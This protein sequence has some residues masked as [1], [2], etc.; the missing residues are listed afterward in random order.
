MTEYTAPLRDMRFV[1]NDLV[2]M[3]RITALPGYEHA[4]PD[5]TD[6]ILEEA[7]KFAGNVLSPLNHSGDKEGARLDADGAHTAAGFA[8]AYRQFVDGG[9]SALGC[10]PAYGGQGLPAVLGTAVKEM[11]NAANMAFS[12]CPLLTT[13]AIEALHLVG[14][15]AQ[16][17]MY[18]PKM[19]EGTWTG[20][21]NLTEPQAGSDL[22]AIR[23]RAVPEGDHYRIYG[24][25]IFITYGDHDMTDNIVHLVLGRLPDAPEGVRG[26][27]LFVVPKFLVKADGSLG[28]RNDAHCISLEHKLGIHASPT[29]VMAFGDKEGA[30]GTLVGEANRGLEYMFIM[31]NRARFDVGLQGIAI[32]ERA[33]QHALDY[34]RNRV[35]G[36]EAGGRGG[37]VAIIKHPDVRRMLMSMKSRTEAMR[38]LAYVVAAALDI[39]QRHPDAPERARNQAMVDLL[40]PVVKGWSTESS[41]DI[42]STGVQIHG[43]MGFIEETGAA[44]YLRDARILT[45]YEGTTGI[46]ANDLIGRKILRDQGAAAR[47]VIAEMRDVSARLASAAGDDFA[48]IR[49]GLNDAIALLEKTIAWVLETW[50]TDPR[51]VLAGAVP[52]LNLFGIVAGG[53][54][55]ARAALAAADHLSAGDNDEPGFYRAKIGTMRFYA[56]HVLSQAS[57]LAH[58]IMHGAAGVLALED[59]AFA[60]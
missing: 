44:Q 31:M 27:S 37:R 5:L 25:K 17:K 14:T 42:A 16:K 9:W 4:E 2:G 38:A 36:N 59:D 56:D 54:Q 26:I 60:A 8:E 45:I 10:D 23:T 41:I 21:M 49:T 34:A 35:Q 39:A 19:V 43:G 48:A 12:L 58:T 28:D 57:G 32:S 46:Q 52:L 1:L 7:A 51:A 29:A 24:Q 13:G 33:Y 6:A 11:W 3:Q 55:S 47:A 53:W 18:L 50:P 22:A 30:I 15:D 40:I 20:T